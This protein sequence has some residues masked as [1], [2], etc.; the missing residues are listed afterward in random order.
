MIL[1]QNK[2]KRTTQHRK[3]AYFGWNYS[4]SWMRHSYTSFW[5]IKNAC[6]PWSQAINHSRMSKDQT[7]LWYIKVKDKTFPIELI[8]FEIN[9]VTKVSYWYIQVFSE[10]ITHLLWIKL[11]LD[12][13]Y[14]QHDN[15]RFWQ[16]KPIYIF[17]EVITHLLWIKLLL[18]VIYLQHN[19]TRFWQT[20]GLVGGG[21]LK[22]GRRRR[23]RRRVW[24]TEQQWQH[25]N[26]CHHPH[27]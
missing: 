1:L 15:T 11:L 26:G 27:E 18:S 12:V 20:K 7:L 13:I 4:Y 25:N 16:R 22:G 17:S 21:T 23:R 3:V 9:M 6:E 8:D 5:L 2:K 19:N 14:L 24:T 10:V